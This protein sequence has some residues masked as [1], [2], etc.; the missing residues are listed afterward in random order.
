MSKCIICT[1]VLKGD[2]ERMISA[3]ANNKHLQEWAKERSLL[4]TLKVIQTH[5]IEHLKHI[6]RAE[7][8]T[9]ELKPVYLTLGTISDL[10][11][12]EYSELLSY[13]SANQIKV[14]RQKNYDLIA[15]IRHLIYKLSQEVETLKD[16]LENLSPKSEKQIL[17]SL[18]EQKLKAQT[19]LLTVVAHIKDV[20]LK[21]EIGVLLKSKELEEKWSYSLVGFKAKLESIPSKVAL[22]LS[23]IGD[24]DAVENVLGKLIDEALEELDHG[25]RQ[26]V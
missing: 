6:D 23:S 19:R 9:S 5:K 21:Q 25:S 7:V 4:L 24:R 13:F 16:T 15:I 1:S 20:Q 22:E 8:E 3:G 17:A 18:K 12:V 26:A 14:N 2:I 10:L 11:D